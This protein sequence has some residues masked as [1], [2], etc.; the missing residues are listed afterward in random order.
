M[1]FSRTGSGHRSPAGQPPLHELSHNTSLTLVGIGDSSHRAWT[2]P[3]DFIRL[4]NPD[5]D[6]SAVE[7]KDER[8]AK[9]LGAATSTLLA[10]ISR[11]LLS[12]PAPTSPQTRR[13][14][15]ST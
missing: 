11:T 15:C 2:R 3:Q 1:G 4:N 13:V 14:L 8:W 12:T 5:G 9:V 7:W 10:T 6:L